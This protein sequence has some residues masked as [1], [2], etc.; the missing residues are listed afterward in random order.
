M[1]AVGITE[2][3][4]GRQEAKGGREGRKGREEGKE[5]VREEGRGL[6]VKTDVVPSGT[7][8]HLSTKP[9]VPATHTSLPGSQ[10]LD[11]CY[12]QQQTCTSLTVTSD[13]IVSI[14]SSLLPV[15]IGHTHSGV[16][17]LGNIEQPSRAL[18]QCVT[19]GLVLKGIQLT[20][21]L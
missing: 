14:D 20:V 16:L 8:W 12:T 7:A 4:K 10:Q 21:T 3:K 13:L 5:R 18:L 1:A 6:R 9:L 15:F 2:L 19:V 17:R 11:C